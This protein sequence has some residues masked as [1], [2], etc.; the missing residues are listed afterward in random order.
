MRRCVALPVVITRNG[1]K[2]G[3][4]LGYLDT[5]LSRG[6]SGKPL[7]LLFCFFKFAISSSFPLPLQLRCRFYILILFSLSFSAQYTT[8]FFHDTR[9]IMAP[10]NFWLKRQL[11]RSSSFTH[12]I[13][14]A[15]SL[16]NSPWCQYPVPVVSSVR[17]QQ[18]QTMLIYCT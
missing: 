9:L 14:H 1:S 17:L 7:V 18:R 6:W 8:S 3:L 15:C 2:M 12:A 4:M 16:L 10:H 5:G 11:P 13:I